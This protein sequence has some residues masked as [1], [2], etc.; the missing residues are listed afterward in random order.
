MTSLILVLAKVMASK[1]ISSIS[2]PM[3]GD[4]GQP[5]GIQKSQIMPDQPH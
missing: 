2:K 3:K 4:W 5:A 1:G